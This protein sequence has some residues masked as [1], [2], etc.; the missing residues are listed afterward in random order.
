MIEIRR[1]R[2]KRRESTLGHRKASLPLAAP[3]GCATLGGPF[4]VREPQRSMPE[5]GKPRFA[6]APLG[7]HA[8]LARVNLANSQPA[9]MD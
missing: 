8:K 9:A 7:R 1:L 4:V 5:Q 2:N 3:F 6:L